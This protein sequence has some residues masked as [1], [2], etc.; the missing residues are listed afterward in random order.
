MNSV[1]QKPAW[2]RR[3][4][5]S[6]D[7][8]TTGALIDSEAAHAAMCAALEVDSVNKNVPR[9]VAESCEAALHDLLIRGRELAAH[10]AAALAAH[11]SIVRAHLEH[12]AS[13]KS[14]MARQQSCSNSSSNRDRLGIDREVQVCPE[15]DGEGSREDVS[16]L[17]GQVAYL[18]ERNS[19]LEVENRSLTQEVAA[20]RE[21]AERRASKL[22]LQKRDAAANAAALATAR[23]V[24]GELRERIADN[25]EECVTR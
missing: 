7:E 15:E 12:A 3:L 1:S 13:L 2:V 17:R 11:E 22:L 25:A 16:R 8:M 9:A 21:T 5:D 6:I 19:K 4:A 18:S 14:L 23:R 10:A 24:N 20:L